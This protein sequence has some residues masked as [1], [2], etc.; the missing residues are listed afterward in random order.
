M[1]KS[2]APSTSAAAMIM[3]VKI[4]P[5]ASG[6]RAMASTAWDPM[7]PMPRPAPMMT[8]PAPTQAPRMPRPRPRPFVS[9][10][11]T[12]TA[13]VLGAGALTPEQGAALLSSPEEVT[14]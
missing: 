4:R 10:P 6:W 12:Q 9:V 2:V 7:A 11:A 5:P 1:A 14:A 13:R 8:S 3:L